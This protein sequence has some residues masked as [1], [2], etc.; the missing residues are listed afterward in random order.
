MGLALPA[1]FRYVSAVERHL[2]AGGDS[3][4]SVAASQAHR[5]TGRCFAANEQ[6]G[7]RPF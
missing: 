2:R 1:A 3:R 6:S 5:F 7:C 4:H